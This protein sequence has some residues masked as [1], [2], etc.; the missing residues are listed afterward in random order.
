MSQFSD[1]VEVI[2]V[3]AY[4]RQHTGA[5]A[6]TAALMIFFGFFVFGGAAGNETFVA[7]SK[8]FVFSLRIGGL[9]LLSAA[10]GCCFGTAYALLAEGLTSTLVGLGIV[11]GG[12]IMLVGAGL[13]LGPIVYLILGLMLAVSGLRTIL[14]F[15]TLPAED[16]EAEEV[17]DQAEQLREIGELRKTDGAVEIDVSDQASPDDSQAA[18]PI[19]FEKPESSRSR[20]PSRRH[21][22]ARTDDEEV[23]RLDDLRPRKTP[24][25]SR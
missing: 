12:A 17:Q 16:V 4:V 20:R 19:V 13:S 9:L 7:G 6:L 3:E 21:L 15:S 25:K 22:G 2:D 8:I 1:H 11:L 10:V 14:D 18:D 23:I 5:C 24:P